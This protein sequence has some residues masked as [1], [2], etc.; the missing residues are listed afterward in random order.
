MG[1]INRRAVAV[2]CTLAVAA[3][4]ASD[5]PPPLPAPPRG[6]STWQWNPGTH[7]GKG[8]GQY[9]AVDEVTARAQADAMVEKGLAAKGYNVFIVDE[10][11]F[12]GRNAVGELQPNTTTWPSGFKAFGDYLRARGISLGIYTDAGPYTCQGCPG[13]AGHEAQDIATFA[14]W[15]ASYIKVCVCA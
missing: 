7:W 15:G 4:A 11:C 6:Y 1:G 13:S 2:A 9:N 14:S 12:A 3:A 5:A 10:P 8:Q